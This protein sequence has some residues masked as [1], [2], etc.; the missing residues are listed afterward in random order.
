MSILVR[1]TIED[2]YKQRV[3]NNL[4]RRAK[5]LGFVLHPVAGD[6]LGGCFLG[7]FASLVKQAL[8][9]TTASTPIEIWFQDEAR[10]GQKGTHAYIWAPIGSRNR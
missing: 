1:H 9:S 8:L 2:R 4:Q 3:L 6:R 7:N 10:V 5:S